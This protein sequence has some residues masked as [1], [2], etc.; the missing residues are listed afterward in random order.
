M[1]EYILEAVGNL[2][3]PVL[4]IFLIGA[5]IGIIS[6][7]N[8][9][10]W[11]IKKFHNVTIAV[12]AGFMAGSLNKVWPWKMLTNKNTDSG[13]HMI[14]LIEKNVLP[15][16][17]EQI[18]GNDAWLEGAIIMAIVGFILIFAIQNLSKKGKTKK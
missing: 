9:L 8:L 7:S 3:L 1:Y 15:G 17:Y 13:G 6:F 12:L 18:P 10:S 5:A 11:L 2:D 4:L 14:S 16:T